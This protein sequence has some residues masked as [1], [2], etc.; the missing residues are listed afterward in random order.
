[1]DFGNIAFHLGDTA[2]HSTCVSF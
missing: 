1:M 2:V